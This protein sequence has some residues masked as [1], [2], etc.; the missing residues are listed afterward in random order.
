MAATTERIYTSVSEQVAEVVINRPEARN[1]LNMDMWRRLRL[2][3]DMLAMDESVRVVVIR[4]E[5]SFSAGADM[6]DLRSL[7]E[8]DTAAGN[9]DQAQECWRVVD[10]TNSAIEDCPKP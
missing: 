9:D 8:Q 7:A 4:G 6:R 5:S 3:I 10:A 1:A 2:A